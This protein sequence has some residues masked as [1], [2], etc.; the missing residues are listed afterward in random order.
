MSFARGERG[1]GRGGTLLGL[2]VLAITLYVGVKVVPV[3]IDGYA[4]RDYLE[5]EARFAA[6]RSQDEEV[7]ARVLRK[8][9]ELE[10]PVAGR[11]I[12]VNRTTTY[13]DI[14]VRYTVPIVTP[15]YT[16]E[17]SFDESVRSPL[18]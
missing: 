2:A 12:Q 9:H 10:L 15:V 14:K 8:A 13:I 17:M 16:Y 5:E 11:N 1:E 4:F 3:L 6:L 7:R 18:F